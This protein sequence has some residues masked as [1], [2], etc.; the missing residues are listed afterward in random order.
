MS[1]SDIDPCLFIVFGATG[2]LACR[3]LLPAMYRLN[4]Q[5]RLP[6][7]LKILGVSRSDMDDVRFRS[8]VRKALESARVG[9]SESVGRWCE[10]HLHYSW[11]AWGN[12]AI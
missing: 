8:K 7:Q 11:S 4:N 10:Q 1:K 5:G 2:D 9:S 12:C 3:K 6:D